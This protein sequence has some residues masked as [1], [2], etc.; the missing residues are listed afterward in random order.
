M[1]LPF[2]PV[3][4]P[5]SLTSFETQVWLATYTAYILANPQI[6]AGFGRAEYFDAKSGLPSDTLPTLAA[7]FANNAIIELRQGEALPKPNAQ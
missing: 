7:S 2:A 3:K 1:I 4:A 6:N 5:K